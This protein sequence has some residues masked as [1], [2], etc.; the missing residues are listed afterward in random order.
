[1]KRKALLILLTCCVIASAFS[2]GEEKPADSVEASD[3]E[4]TV[5][6]TA[7]ETLDGL[8]ARTL[9]SD[10]L[11]DTDMK[12]YAFT[13]VSEVPLFEHIFAETITG[14]PINDA[15]Y[16]RNNRIEE[17][18]NMK[19]DMRTLGTATKVAT[20]GKEIANTVLAGEDV[21]QLVSYNAVW[22]G[23]HALSDIFTNWN[24]IKY[25]DF[26][27]PWWSPCTTEELQYKDVILLS[28]GDFSLS[29]IGK[30]YCMYYDKVA[31]DSYGI[32]NVYGLVTDGGWTIDRLS[33][34]TRG[35]YTDVNSDGKRD[36]GDYYGFSSDCIHN[37]GA[38]LWAFDNPIMKTAKDGT[39]ELVFKT[40]KLSAILE[41]LNKLVWES[42]GTYC[43]PDYVNPVNGTK[44]EL[45]IHKFKDCGALFANGTLEASLTYFRELENDYGII[46]YP[47]WDEAQEDYHCTVST[48]FA[49][50]AVPKTVREPDKTGIIT[51]ALNAESYKTVVPVYYDLVLKTKLTRDLESLA[52]LDTIVGSRM[53]DFGYVF[54]GSTIGTSLKTTGAAFILRDL[55]QKNSNDIE[56]YFASLKNSVEEHYGDVF[57]LFADY[58]GS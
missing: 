39:K 49:A 27:K 20:V 11:P 36:Y 25:V 35:I 24:D 21:Y 15:V 55:V 29:A 37:I 32:K 30:T 44:N 28:V 56:S 52:L 57:R 53:F 4:S 33:E 23:S 26:T 1:M 50:F 19:F 12:G 18:F 51:E 9:V 41:R 58:Y 48:D 2:C 38:Y 47:K 17:R 34:L 5:S 16:D 14:E 54:N 31:A 40:K 43:T 22:L 13:T 6:E 42:E 8:D 10:G 46:P 7:A 3:S 45:G